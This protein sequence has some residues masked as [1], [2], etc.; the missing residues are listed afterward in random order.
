MKLR[1][2]RGVEKRKGDGYH[3]GHG[4]ESMI[5]YLRSRDRNKLK[6]DVVFDGTHEGKQWLLALRYRCAS[7]QIKVQFA[8]KFSIYLILILLLRNI[9]KTGE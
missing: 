7:N 5:E 8:P 2:I 1:G 3:E 6:Q 9:C 4:N